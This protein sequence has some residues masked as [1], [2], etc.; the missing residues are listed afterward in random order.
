MP[1]GRLCSSSGSSTA[2]ATPGPAAA[3]P[4]PTLT[5]AGSMP[6]ARCSASF[7]S[8]RRAPPPH[9]NLC[10]PVMRPAR[11]AAPTAAL[12]RRAIAPTTMTGWPLGAG[13]RH[14][15]DQVLHDSAARTVSDQGPDQAQQ[16]LVLGTLAAPDQEFA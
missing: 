1:R 8:I 11:A 16:S 13:L 7:W 9:D 15:D 10:S 4:V 2:A 6:R 12:R 14:T 3:P 5:R